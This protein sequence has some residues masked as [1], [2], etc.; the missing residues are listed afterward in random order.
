LRGKK[1]KRFNFSRKDGKG[2]KPAGF[3]REKSKAE[4]SGD[5][6][7]RH[8]PCGEEKKKRRVGTVF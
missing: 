2:E 3:S 7:V 4:K 8:E 5:S 6:A 1:K